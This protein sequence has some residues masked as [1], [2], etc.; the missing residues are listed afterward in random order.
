MGCSAAKE[1][2][3]E[4]GRR[5][6]SVDQT[7]VRDPKAGPV[8][9]QVDEEVGRRHNVS[10]IEDV[11]KLFPDTRRH[12]NSG[13]NDTSVMKDYAY[14]KE[15]AS[16]E[17]IGGIAHCCHKGMKPEAPNQDDFIIM[18]CGTEFGLYGVFDGHGPYG[19]D[20]SNYVNQTLP[21]LL[22]RSGKFR[23]DIG[24]AITDA[25]IQTHKGIF[26]KSAQMEKTGKF[27][28]QMSG[29]TC[30][31]CVFR[32]I[33]GQNMMY[34]GHAGDSRCILGVGSDWMKMK[35]LEMTPDHKPEIPAERARINKTGIG[36]VRLRPNDIPHRVFKKGFQLPGLAMSRSLGDLVAQEC[37]VSH[38]PEIRIEP[39]TDQH[40]LML[41]CSDGVWEFLSNE[42]ALGIVQNHVN[43]FIKKAAKKKGGGEADA[44]KAMATD[45]TLDKIIRDNMQ[46]GCEKLAKRS[47][48][49]W[50][51]NE[52]D[53][54]D[55][56]T[57]IA[58]YIP[59]IFNPA[60][61]SG[62]S[63]AATGTAGTGTA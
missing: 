42:E 16:K 40:Q 34:F 18:Q 63:P 22:C 15:N 29:T 12:S 35:A 23:T 36:E 37:G 30:T 27:S 24:G 8:V 58:V 17:K 7:R 38:V 60:D 56:I 45:G 14:K 10:S 50:V 59:N 1:A 43:D 44:M 11:L 52:G 2:V 21:G 55:D 32:Q 48:D 41:M 61:G 31:V 4:P 53:V 33:D 19:H 62:T 25:F 49:L 46:A 54:V 13:I 20:V 3:P 57:V 9:E 26:K 5:R 47:F 28:A 39:V 51:E 6:L